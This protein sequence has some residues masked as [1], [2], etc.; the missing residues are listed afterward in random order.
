VVIKYRI[1]GRFKKAEIDKVEV[2]RE[3]EY[4]VFVLRNG[5]EVRDG[6]KTEWAEYYDTWDEAHAALM[7]DAEQKITNARR[8]LEYAHGFQG[9]VKGMKRPKVA[10]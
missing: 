8:S 2:E 4:F 6:K 1:A 3:T 10:A 7:K 9:N 5:K